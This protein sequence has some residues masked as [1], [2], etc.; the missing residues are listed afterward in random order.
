MRIYTGIGDSGHTRLFGGE[1]VSK[2]NLRVAAYGELDELNSF[3]GFARRAVAP[4]LDAILDRLQNELF[5]L[6]GELASPR[7]KNVSIV[8]EDVSNL[9]AD[10]DRL[11]AGG[12][13]L[14]N[15]ILPGGAGGSAELHMARS[16]CRRAERAVVRLHEEEPVRDEVLRYV[17]RLSDL[18]FA[19]ARAAQAGAGEQEIMWRSRQKGEGA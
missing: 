14:R 8:S 7:G 11:M 10:I 16:V 15:F 13:E 2:D 9:E 1:D 17:N 18:L 3:L 6:G 12:P 5:E 19:M 4:E